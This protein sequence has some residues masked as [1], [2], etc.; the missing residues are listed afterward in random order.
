MLAA[1]IYFGGSLG[2]Y[3]PVSF[4]L[5]YLQKSEIIGRHIK[6]IFESSGIVATFVSRRPI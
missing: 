5:K 4:D 2:F 6:V 1:L 3:V